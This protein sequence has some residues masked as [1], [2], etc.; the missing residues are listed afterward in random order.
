MI[1]DIA[2]A[3]AARIGE[4]AD[5][6]GIQVA[7]ENVPFTPPANE[8]YL[9]VHDMPATPRTIDLGLRCRTYS[10]VY[11]INVVAPAGT[12]RAD[13]SALASQVAELFPE[14]LEI[15]GG[16]FTCWISSTPGIFRGVPTPV[17]YTVPVS[18][19][20]RADIST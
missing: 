18:F 15:E 6:E 19:N 17:S 4:W 1:P 10:G 13:V 20:Y 2:A 14:G 11:Q 12:G 16:G 9:A 7:W 8:I 5:A 3:L